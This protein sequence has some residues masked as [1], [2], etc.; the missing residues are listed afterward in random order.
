MAAQ[1]Q[2]ACMEASSRMAA[3]VASMVVVEV[4]ELLGAGQESALASR[5]LE[6]IRGQVA[7]RSF[8]PMAMVY[9]DGGDD[10]GHL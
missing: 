3:T 8:H 6:D 5:V 7:Q 4:S 2:E 1:D 10:D 9:S